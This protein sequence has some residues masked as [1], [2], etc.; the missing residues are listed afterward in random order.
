MSQWPSKSFI[1]SL[2]R[3]YKHSFQFT[4]HT[5]THTQTHELNI[6]YLSIASH[7][8]SEIW[9]QRQRKG[10][11]KKTSYTLISVLPQRLATRHTCTHKSWRRVAQGTSF[12]RMSWAVGAILTKKK[13]P[14]PKKNQTPTCGKNKMGRCFS[15][16]SNTESN[17]EREQEVQSR[18]GWTWGLIFTQTAGFS[19]RREIMF[20]NGNKMYDQQNK[21]NIITIVTFWF[22]SFF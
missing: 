17:G 20:Q 16:S 8:H 19:S 15:Y 13:K 14:K 18:A 9:E 21:F 6:S 10:N 11:F 12:G 22:C 5:C 3:S 7:L 1:Y 4:T 2:W